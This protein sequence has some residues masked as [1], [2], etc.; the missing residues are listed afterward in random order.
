MNLNEAIARE[1]ALEPGSYRIQ[2]DMTE[3]ANIS[4]VRDVLKQNGITASVKQY[5]AG[6]LWHLAI[7]YRKPAAEAGISALPLAII[8]LIGFTMIIGLVGIGIFKIQ[9]I[10][11]SL[12][13]LALVV[14]GL[15]IVFVV[16]K[17]KVS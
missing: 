12:T 1:Q 17:K 4:A 3:P 16:L 10:T 15:A 6:G 14:G 9:A 8:P 7:N 5:Q 13:K 11:D 2:F